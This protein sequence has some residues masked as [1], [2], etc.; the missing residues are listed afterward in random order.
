MLLV[1]EYCDRGN[2]REILE[3]DDRYPSDTACTPEKRLR[4]IHGMASGMSYLHSRQPPIVHGKAVQV[5]ISL[6]LG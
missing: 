1:L 2:L 5:D 6:T 4:M 3:D